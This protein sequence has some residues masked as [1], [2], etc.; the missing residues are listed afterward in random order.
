[1]GPSYE[2]AQD[3]CGII[4]GQWVV[5]DLRE[6]L[7]LHMYIHQQ[8]QVWAALLK[9]GDSDQWTALRERLARKGTQT[10]EAPC[11]LKKDGAGS[12]L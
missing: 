6:T 11:W 1:M 10:A 2:G 4:L 12:M 3:L 7:A 5:V 9:E 8:G